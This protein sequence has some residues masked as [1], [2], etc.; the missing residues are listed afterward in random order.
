MNRLLIGKGNCSSL[1]EYIIYNEVLMKTVR[2]H[3]QY[4]IYCLVSIKWLM[5]VSTHRWL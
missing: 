5:S 2:W 1:S 4:C 3:Y